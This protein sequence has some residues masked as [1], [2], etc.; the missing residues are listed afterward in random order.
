Y[1]LAAEGHSVL[2]LDSG[3][4]LS[5]PD[6]D[7]YERMLRG[8]NP[9]PWEQPD[10]DLYEDQANP[11]INLN[12][13]RIKAV[14]GTTLHWNANAQRLQP[15]DFKMKSGFGVS[16]DW[17][18]SYDDIEP[19][20]VE[21]EREMGVSG[22]DAPGHPPRS[23]PF[24][25][26]AFEMSYA[27]RELVV[28]AFEAMDLPIG[29]NTS[30]INSNPHDNRP[31]CAV[32]STCMPMCP[33]NARYTALHHINKAEETGRVEVRA[34]CHV[35][36]IRLEGKRK[37]RV[38]Q[39]VDEA[40]RS[41]E[42]HARHFVLAG[43]GVEIPRLLLLSAG[44]EAGDDG[45]ANSS[46]LVGR[47]YT[48]HPRIILTG[49]LPEN[50]GPHRN[51]YSTSNCWA[52]YQHDR[53]P[54]IGNVM[55]SPAPNASPDPAD[56]AMASDAWGTDLLEAIKRKYGRDLDIHVKGDMLPKPEN[57]VRLSTTTRDV[58][59]DPVPVIEMR[60][61]DFDRR[62]LDHGAERAKQVFE[63][64]RATDI[65]GSGHG[66]VRNHLMGTTSMGDSP[67]SSVCDQWGRCHDLDNLYIV[68]SSLF[69]SPGCS[70]PTLT[71]GALALRTADY[72]TR[73]VL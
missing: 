13:E 63:H 36:R 14:G 44:G 34:N 33:I 1:R 67:Q 73:Q 62:A 42:A 32:F 69:P 50:F 9:W 30:A 18:M 59:G 10:R 27:E 22:G 31:G 68:S 8:G 26:P 11:S 60:L 20:Y 7:R 65:S 55:L 49:T 71:I 4:R 72:L 41:R 57:R 35:R 46:G 39:Y 47:N 12:H 38:V 5:Y 40:G 25:L 2:I 64:L 54:E 43:G 51:G 24:P 29:A 3:P 16:E 23:A 15:G 66:I 48:S 6:M 28:P 45:L 58:Y 61:S 52:L 70:S 56:I 21:A 19:W 17:P 37:V 53:L